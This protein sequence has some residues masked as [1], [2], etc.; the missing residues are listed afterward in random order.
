MIL[1]PTLGYFVTLDPLGFDWKQ[2]DVMFMVL[3]NM[4]GQLSAT[5]VGYHQ[6]QL[7]FAFQQTCCGRT[8]VLMIIVVFVIVVVIIVAII[9][10]VAVVV[11][12]LVIYLMLPDGC[13]YYFL[14]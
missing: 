1:K 3:G 4:I 12:F 7:L 9:I 10:V 11:I 2:L 8:G 14:Y 13:Y 5:S 6:L